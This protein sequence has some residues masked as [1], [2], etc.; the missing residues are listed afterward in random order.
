MVALRSTTRIYG[1]RVGFGEG[2]AMNAHPQR[3]YDPVL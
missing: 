1:A 3:E 2:G